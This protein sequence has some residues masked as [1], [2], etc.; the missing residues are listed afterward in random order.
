MSKYR[1]EET[2]PWLTFNFSATQNELWAKLGEAYS[3]TQHLANTAMPPSV[4]KQLAKVV[5]RKGALATT[6]IEGN[7]LSE[8]EANDIFDGVRKLPASQQYLEQEILNILDALERLDDEVKLGE[9]FKLTP[10]WLAEQNRRVLDG[11]ETEEHVTPGEY[12][13][14]QLLV[15]NVYRPPHP[16]EAPVLVERMCEWLNRDYILPSQDKDKKESERFFLAFFGAVLGHLYLAW[17]HPFGDGNGRT[18]R[19]LEVAILAHSEV[20]PWVAS[21]SLSDYY[22]R[23]RQKYYGA[24]ERASKANDVVGFVHYAVTGF[25][26]QLRY[27]TEFVHAWLLDL[28]WS[29]YV[30][31]VLSEPRFGAVQ[32]R[33]RELVL[34][35]SGLGWSGVQRKD[36]VGLS[37]YLAAAYAG[38]QGRA[39]ARDLNV[40]RRKGLLSEF[41]GKWYANKYL[42][43]AFLPK[44]QRAR[45]T[46]TPGA[47][48]SV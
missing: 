13:T 45:F 35:V 21:N 14:A 7:T 15:G 12:S 47:V 22:N 39:V 16:V 3:K 32:E 30:Y 40:L 9:E 4:A 48:D 43:Y 5:M 6:A 23:T 26:E 36:I 11:L 41:G 20:V 1:Y 33:Q 38:L 44:F 27:S 8:H 25:V 31:E 2:H 46:A 34:A 24:L 28:V 10:E 29:D 19:L 18:A 37:P 42:M 17:I